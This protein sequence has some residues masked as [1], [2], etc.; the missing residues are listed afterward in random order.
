MSKVRNILPPESFSVAEV[1]AVMEAVPY[2]LEP[3][4][5]LQS[6]GNLQRWFPSQDPITVWLVV[7]TPPDCP[8]NAMWC[9]EI[10]SCTQACLKAALGMMFLF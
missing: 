1:A 8:L 3:R 7:W 10:T 6:L 9:D 4:A 5:L 2:L